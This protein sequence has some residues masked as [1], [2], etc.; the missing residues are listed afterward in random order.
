MIRDIIFDVGGVLLKYKE[1][2]YY[3]YISKKYGLSIVKVS[4]TLN[5]MIAKLE[6]GKMTI[7]QMRSI[8]SKEFGIPNADLEWVRFFKT[9]AEPDS[10]M[11]ALVKRLEH[12]YRVSVL[13]NISRSRYVVARKLF[14]HDLNAYKVFTSCYMGMRKPTEKIYLTVLNDLGAKPE[15][16]VFID[17][18]K[19][20]VD[21]AKKVGIRALQFKSHEQIAKALK[22]IG[23]ETA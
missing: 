23:A 13:S 15:E 8:A 3:R 16:T 21:G 20:N 2:D 7:K 17:N 4:H 12:N 19:V 6:I 18:L 14:L 22:R 1:E 11:I 9:A 10:Y 5:P